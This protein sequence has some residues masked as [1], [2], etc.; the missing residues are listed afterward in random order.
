MKKK[1]LRR[2]IEELKEK[3]VVLQN[4][5]KEW[6]VWAASQIPH[7]KQSQFGITYIPHMTDIEIR[8]A[9]ESY[10]SSLDNRTRFSYDDNGNRT[11]PHEPQRV[12]V[13]EIVDSYHKN[14]CAFY[15]GGSCT[16]NCET[17]I[18]YE[19]DHMDK[20]ENSYYEEQARLGRDDE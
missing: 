11:D 10:L 12:S 6:K 3:W 5:R 13:S 4:I 1:K 8:W 7:E 19:S 15:V 18:N 20:M 9:V 16:K 17:E 14:G 2:R